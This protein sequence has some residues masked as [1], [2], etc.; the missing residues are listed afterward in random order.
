MLDRILSS[1]NPDGLLYDEIRPSDL[2]PLERRLSDNWGY[3]YG[4][5]YTHYMVTGEPRFRDAV[6][7][8]LRNLPKYRGHDW[9]N[10]SQ[11]GYADSRAPQ[12]VAG[13]V[14]GRRDDALPRRGRAGA[15]DGAHRLGA[16]GRDR[17]GR[18]RPVERREARSGPAVSAG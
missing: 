11:D 3:V 5:V 6:V 15:G 1:A 4:A 18:S 10:G 2:Q 7:R 13:V 17:G 9:E 14:R 12:R 8:V 16:E